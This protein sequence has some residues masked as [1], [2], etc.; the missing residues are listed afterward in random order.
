ML[1]SRER[2]QLRKRLQ[3]TERAFEAL[4]SVGVV[5]PKKLSRLNKPVQQSMMIETDNPSIS[6][7]EGVSLNL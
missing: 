7:V 1:I 4:K 3:N 5:G 2:D 6:F